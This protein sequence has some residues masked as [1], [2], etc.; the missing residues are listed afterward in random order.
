MYLLY[1][2]EILKIPASTN[3]YLVGPTIDVLVL[4]TI[5]AYLPQALSCPIN[6][7][8]NKTNQRKITPML[9]GLD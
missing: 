6:D 5:T 3:D 1:A 7:L 9:S 8:L 4:G 2:V